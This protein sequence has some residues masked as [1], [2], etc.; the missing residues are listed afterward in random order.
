MSFISWPVAV[1]AAS[2]FLNGVIGAVAYVKSRRLSIYRSFAALGFSFAWWS[3]AYIR[4]GPEFTDPFW[5]R[6]LFSPLCWLPASALSFVWALRGMANDVRR[7]RVVPMY[8]AG[9][10]VL[11]M[12]W[13]GSLSLERFRLLFIALATP[14]FAAAVWLLFDHWR[15]AKGAERNRRGYLLAAAVIAVCGGMTDFLPHIGVPMPS[16]ANASF[17][18]YSL[19]VLAAIERHHL[20]DL[21]EA[22]SLVISLVGVSLVLSVVLASSAWLTRRLEGQLF[23]NF[24]VLSLVLTAVLPPVWERFNRT[25]NRLFFEVQ[26]HR[27]RALEE[28]EGR[29]ESAGD[30]LKV[31]EAVR[32]TVDSLWGATV[33]CLWDAR[34]LRILEPPAVMPE[35]LRDCAAQEGQVATVAALSRSDDPSSRALLELLKERRAQAAVPILRADEQVGT[36]LLGVPKQ[37]FYDLGAIRWLRRVA[38]AVSRTVQKAELLQAALHTDRLAQMGALA[39]GIAHEIRNPLSAM[40]GAV[41]LLQMPLPDGQRA[42]YAE[43]LKS[44]VRRLDEVLSGL[45]DY[46]APRAGNARAEWTEAWSRVER[47]LKGEL[48]KGATVEREG[49]PLEL[50]VSG[51]HLQQILVNLVK[52][53]ARAVAERDDGRIRVSA[54]P[55]ERLARLEVR[56]NGGGIPEDML[57]R[58]FAPF[59]TA[60]PGGAGLGLAMVRRLAELYGGGVRAENPPEGGA[61]FVVELP[62]FQRES[63]GERPAA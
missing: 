35:R 7:N 54:A 62:V 53:A 25:F 23:L 32:S 9:F 1:A 39:A 26:A 55:G 59:A 20:L 30:L 52:N 41:E 4:C 40:Q 43:V 56:D 11:G 36:L 28:L 10:V 14:A 15:A 42:E 38:Q 49:E 37:G 34:A 27:E 17:M 2:G 58:L 50:A 16:L 3:M 5:M 48:P 46:A 13:H 44:E 31:E 8:V 12:L 29:L 60:S 51:A 47:L 45:L 22:A 6:V 33:E 61:R 19:I 21:R 24:F 57:G 63:A 18:A